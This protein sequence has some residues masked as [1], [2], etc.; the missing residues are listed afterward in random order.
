MKNALMTVALRYGAI[1]LDIDRKDIDSGSEIS[2][3][4][5]A[6]LLTLSEKGFVVEEELLH[7]LKEDQLE[8][9]TDV[10]DTALGIKLNWAPLVKGWDTPTGE[11]FI[12]HCITFYANYLGGRSAMTGTTLPCG[13]FI[14]DGTFPIERYNGCPFCGTPFKTADFVYTGQGSRKRSL[15]LMT[16][17][18]MKGLQLS[19]LESKVPLDG[20]QTESLKALVG[21][22]GLPDGVEI[23]MKETR[24]IVVDALVQSNIPVTEQF[25]SAPNDILRY[26]W[27]KKTGRLQIIEPKVL[28][29]HAAKL[30]SHMVKPL[31]KSAESGARMKES[32]RLKYGRNICAMVASWMNALPMDAD[33]ACENMHPKRGMWV[34]MI[35]ALRLGEYSRRP[36]FESLAKLL[37]TFYKDEYS[38][39][40][41][42]LDKALGINCGCV[43]YARAFSLLEQRPGTFARS[44]FSLML[45]VGPQMALDSFRKILDR[46]PPRL[47]LSLANAAETYFDTSATRIARPITGSTK[48]IPYNRKLD[49][50]TPEQRTSLQRSVSDLYKEAMLC[51]FK[52]EAAD[53]TASGKMFIDKRLFDIPV[54]IGD[55]TST[56]QDT[57][58]ALQ[59]TR[60]RVEGDKVRLFMQWGKG[61]KAQH[62]DMDLSAAICYA[63][64]HKEDC[65]YFNL[66]PV[67][68]KHSGDIRSIPDLVGT[69]EYIELDIPE[70][71]AAG[72]RYVAFTCNAY[73]HGAIS[74]NLM[75]GWMN[76]SNPMALSEETGVAY[77]PS[78]VQHNVRISEANLAKG[79]VFG[80]LDIAKKE[81]LWLEMPFMGQ[82]VGQLDTAAVEALHRR[83][84]N[85]ISVGELLSLKAEAQGFAI[86]DNEEDADPQNRFT[87]VWAMDAS[88]VSS[89]LG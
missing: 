86:T 54:S 21:E 70:L 75:V 47:V 74:P 18:D 7:A 14:P 89:L 56:I 79:L 83:L 63:D 12:D 53:S 34:R 31:D 66:A 33:E 87:Y 80:V 24:T 77:D 81:I 15:R 26:L 36:G 5:A 3:S 30:G 57:S 2:P 20:T 76:S 58:A 88:A 46:I 61:L 42:E 9:I 43:D 44:L 22:F 41:R 6:F 28:V 39:W 71:E 11:S 48:V 64:G 50:F 65:A 29:A 84:A 51:K 67:G 82:F 68:A 78:T 27:Y 85:K 55:R 37:D 60:F 32:L 52:S 40:K 19:L 49:N 72:A 73:S 25:F 13:H 35:R 59:G 8:N 45:R 10:I 16:L 69:A 23:G 38:V 1:F 17:S 4:V 62:L